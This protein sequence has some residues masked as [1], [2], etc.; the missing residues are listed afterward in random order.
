MVKIVAKP[1]DAPA[2]DV[3]EDIGFTDLLERANA[4]DGE[5]GEGPGTEVA[6]VE[7]DPA[8][9]MAREL[10]AL[11]KLPRAV[12]A[13]RFA[14]W[15]QFDTVW[16]DAQLQAIAGALAALCIANGWD[17]GELLSGKYGPWIGLAIAVGMPAFV[18][19]DAIQGERQART[20]Q[21]V[22]ERTRQTTAANNGNAK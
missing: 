11:L 1:V 17:L 14:W 19:W 4:I 20:Q 21:A 10:F 5:P 18:T 22:A 15:P 12:A 3:A 13:K 9:V 6:K 7:V 2:A 8:E 16:S